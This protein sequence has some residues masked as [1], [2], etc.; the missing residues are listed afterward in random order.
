MHKET[1]IYHGRRY[2]R[3]PRSKIRSHRFYFIA[4]SKRGNRLLHRD[5]W[6]DAHGPIPP[7]YQIHHIDG[8][9]LNNQL[10]N[11]ECLTAREHLAKHPEALKELVLKSAWSLERARPM[12]ALWHK[13]KEGRKFAKRVSAKFLRLRRTRKKCKECRKSFWGLPWSLFCSNACKSRK[14]RRMGLD[15]IEKECERCGKRFLSNRY[16]KVRFC[17]RACARRDGRNTRSRLQPQ[18]RRRT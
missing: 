9:S 7:G 15:N 10:S 4:S 8:N 3:Y 16:E 14:R 12:A 13:S 18:R 17:S 1:V 5:I 6:Q 2:R 11:L